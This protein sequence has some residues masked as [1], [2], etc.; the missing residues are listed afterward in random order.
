MKM[1]S[2]HFRPKPEKFIQLNLRIDGKKQNP[3]YFNPSYAVVQKI[4]F[5]SA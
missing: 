5:F 1:E 2:P 4:K 3:L